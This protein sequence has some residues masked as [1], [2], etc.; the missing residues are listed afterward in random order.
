MTDIKIGQTITG[1]FS[2]SD[3]K[4]SN[5]SNTTYYYDDYDLKDLTAFQQGLSTIKRSAIDGSLG[6]A[7]VNADTNKVISGFQISDFPD[8]YVGVSATTFIDGVNS[9]LGLTG[10]SFPGVNYKIR[11]FSSHFGNYE[12]A[13]TDQGKGTSIVSN[14]LSNYIGSV[15]TSGI[16]F[17]QVFNN[18]AAT[19]S[20][21]GLVF[22]TANS[23]T[24]TFTDIA[25]GSNRKL[26]AIGYD[27]LYQFDPSVPIGQQVKKLG[28]IKDDQGNSVTGN[29]NALEFTDNN[30]LYA[31]GTNKFYQIDPNTIT[32]KLLATLPVGFSSS[33][34]LTYDKT[35]N[36]LLATS[37]DTNS[38]TNILWQIPLNNPSQATKIGQIGFN[39]VY[40]LN[41]ENGELIGFSNPDSFSSSAQRI[42]I[43]LI[44]GKGTFDRNITTNSSSASGYS[45]NINING[46]SR[47]PTFDVV[48]P[49][50]DQIPA[51]DIDY[52]YEFLSKEVAYKAS[53]KKGDILKEIYK[54][55]KFKDIARDYVVNEVF[56]DS[57]TGFYALGLTSATSAPV[58]VIR[59]TEFETTDGLSDF[60][61][62]GV[63]FDQYQK[64]NDN[65]SKW[66]AAASK[67]PGNKL[68]DITGHS[69]GGAL[70][71]DFAADATY[72]GQKLGNIITFNSPG[73]AA[74]TADKF[75]TENASR[76]KHY[77]VSADVI[78]L[79]GEKFISGGYEVFDSTTLNL[80]DNH[81]KPILVP[82]V[83]YGK[84]PVKEGSTK[85]LD[86]KLV[87]GDLTNDNNLF[88]INSKLFGY[89]DP[90]Y[91]ASLAFVES[92]ILATPELQKLKLIPPALLF[93]GTIEASR[94]RIGG[95]IATISTLI[96]SAITG[97]IPVAGS[98][99][100]PEIKLVP[101]V[102]E[103][104]DANLKFN[105]V[106]QTI[107]GSANILIPAGI[108]IGGSLG[109]ARGQLDSVALNADKLNIPIA[110]TG[111]S[112][113]SI[114][115]SVK[116]LTSPN[117]IE[118]GGK[119]GITDSLTGRIDISLPFP[120]N[121][122]ID[123]IPQHVWSLDVTGQID[124][125][126]LTGTGDLTIL[127]GLAKGSAT[128]KLDW[129][130]HLLSANANL[131]ILNGFI[132]AKT[133]FIANSNSDIV[134]AGDAAITVPNGIIG[135]GT[136]VNGK[137]KLQY[138][139]DNISSND[140]VAIYGE[141]R[142][143]FGNF[144][145]SIKVSF[146]G[147]KI[148]WNAEKEIFS[149]PP[150]P[151]VS[152]L[153]SLSLDPLS[154]HQEPSATFL[155]ST[156]QGGIQSNP[157]LL[158]SATATNQYTV[159]SNAQWLILN[160]AWGT[161]NSSV[162]VKLKSPDGKV[163]NESDFAANN[164][165]IVNDLTDTQNRSVIISKPLAGNWSI[166]VV[167]PIGLSSLSYRA[168]RD[169]VAPT[170]E[171]DL[172]VNAGDGNFKI[173]YKAIDPDSNAKVSLFY[174]T[175]PSKFNGAL[176]K[177]DLAESDSV[178]S[179]A[180]NAKEL[181][182]GD[183]YVYASI[184]D[185]D[186]APVLKYAPGKVTISNS[187]TINNAPVASKP[188]VNASAIQDKP[189]TLAL[190]V[191]AFTDTD[192]G[193][194]LTY[195]ATLANGA[196]LPTWLKLDTATGTFTGTPASTNLG[197]LQVKV[198]ATDK[199]QATANSTFTLD[200]VNN[201]VVLP[202]QPLTLQKA[203]TG[204]TWNVN[205]SG[206]VKV[207][208]LGKSTTQLN[209]IG[210]FKLDAT[211]KVNGIA[212]GAAGF[213]KA[214]IESGSV[215]FTALPDRTT[216]GLALSHSFQVNNGERLGFFLV[217]NGSVEDDLKANNFSNVITSADLVNPYTTSPAQ[218]PLQVKENQGVYTLDWK[219]GDK[220]LSFN[221]Q[222]DPAPDTSL[223]S[224]SNQQGKKE[225]E[226]LD[227]RAF[228]GQNIQA[229]FT[230]KRE[231]G[232]N[233]SV[234]FYKI[235]DVTGTITS[236]NGQ[237]F[238]PGDSGYAQA[239]LNNK[240]S[241]LD[242]AGKNGQTVT[243]EKVLQGG[244]IYAPILMSN[245]TASRPNGDNAFTAFSLGNVDRTDHVR[246]LGSNTF[247]FEDLVGGGDKDFNDVIVQ[248]SF[249]IV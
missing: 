18:A 198:T 59:G 20:D 90:E 102:W 140:F 152:A 240:I 141:V 55:T 95:D 109:F 223:A 137:F 37:T 26:Y 48:K 177:N 111:A 41:F 130:Q 120:F 244:S 211:N 23:T 42:K 12:L 43:D 89:F 215:V 52:T 196:V 39:N 118:F 19:Y 8:V 131:S 206:K 34:D 219:Q 69:L 203:T 72:K 121:S 103:L 86:T 246:L 178:S 15:G 67:L 68:P 153:R 173:G 207:S 126:S 84:D 199:A 133:G 143:Q 44:T 170:I 58:L 213:A 47:I 235:D 1:S 16:V 65:I 119:T 158:V 36:R 216:D 168:F 88:N 179:Y 105:T 80:L 78:S 212:P 54:D 32:A 184:E 237:K 217:A 93:R 236:S 73:I 28:V 107:S 171:L 136:S 51:G 234:S 210:I 154:S 186:T 63:G 231:A 226:V 114:A 239:A 14:D 175:D 247:G 190:P 113:Q 164:I 129:N 172:I 232:Y 194:V 62:E 138:I 4:F 221:F 147:T 182:A 238:K 229:T 116:N 106:E 83:N 192:A 159:Q 204:D 49:V 228:T 156:N 125:N 127:G 45:T 76:V 189:F 64:N 233:D 230:L 181:A 162:Q 31:I 98:F 220:N 53:W 85:A 187:A 155:T 30:N 218:V 11:V 96:A 27:S 142:N 241:G 180:W 82:Q 167:N 5:S 22:P 146:D 2:S 122:L 139:N 101:N 3:P 10:S 176:I 13:V 160:A 245:V 9:A 193:D 91:L 38:S 124:K 61:S 71:Q 222:V 50:I 17:P 225:G 74:D 87:Y 202:T 145:K 174:S 149:L 200:V 21:S 157:Q 60:N 195:S 191:G 97:D 115:G 56:D 197:S 108:V 128:A 99:Y 135:A 224:I 94:G 183:Y 163:I 248:T 208:L 24:D 6:I 35:N 144:N 57:Q 112:L 46:S 77:I 33:G 117:L 134:L 66:L 185:G 132:S 7:L 249:K 201:P 151:A 209:E 150:Q 205:G 165:A 29:L 242:L 100:V 92:I 25:I 243:V 40:G 166:E 169:S 70:A 75:K 104:K 79:G 188:L 161:T 110:A 214:A 81:I 227:L 148:D 123:G